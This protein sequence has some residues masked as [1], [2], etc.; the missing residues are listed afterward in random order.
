ME[1]VDSLLQ[2]NK[3]VGE[4]DVDPSSWEDL[5]FEPPGPAIQE[6]PQM[7]E[8]ATSSE[9]A[10]PGIQYSATEIF[11]LRSDRARG[12]LQL[13]KAELE[14]AESR[15]AG[16]LCEPLEAFL[17]EVPEESQ[18]NGYRYLLRAEELWNLTLDG[19]GMDVADAWKVDIH[20]AMIRKATYKGAPA[21]NHSD[22][23]KIPFDGLSR[24]FK[25]D[26]FSGQ[27]VCT[28]QLRALLSPCITEPLTIA[29]LPNEEHCGKLVNSWRRRGNLMMQAL[30]WL[31]QLGSF[32]DCPITR[33]FGTER[34]TW[35]RLQRRL[36]HLLCQAAERA[37]CSIAT[38]DMPPVQADFK[39]HPA[40]KDGRKL[41]GDCK[42][43]AELAIDRFISR[44]GG[45]QQA[46]YA[47]VHRTTSDFMCRYTRKT[48][49]TIKEAF[50]NMRIKSLG[51][52]CDSS[53]KAKMDA[54]RLLS[55][56]LPST[57]P[58]EDK[59]Q[60]AEMLANSRSTN[61]VADPKKGELRK[62]LPKALNAIKQD[63]LSSRQELKALINILSH[64]GVS[65]DLCWPRQPLIPADPEKEER[66]LHKLTLAF[67][68]DRQTGISKWDTPM[69]TDHVRL[70]ICPDQGGPMFCCYQYL[71]HLGASVALTRDELLLVCTVN[72]RVQAWPNHDNVH[73]QSHVLF[74][75]CQES[76]RMTTLCG[77]LFRAKKSPWNTSGFAATLAEARP[78]DILMEMFQ[79][80]I[81]KENGMEETTD[82]KLNFTRVMEILGQ[83]AK[84]CSFSHTAKRFQMSAT[85]LLIFWSAMEVGKNPF[86]ILEDEG[87]ATQNQK[88]Y[89]KTV[90]LCVKA[91]TNELS[92]GIFRVARVVLEPFRELCLELVP[93]LQFRRCITYESILS[94]ALGL[95]L[96]TVHELLQYSLYLRSS[97]H[98]AAGLISTKEPDDGNTK[99]SILKRMKAEWQVVLTMESKAASAATLAANCHHTRYQH[100]RE[101]M[102]CMEKN[103]YRM[104]TESK[105]MVSAWSPDFCQ[106]ASLESMFGDMSDAVKRAGRADCGGLASLHAVG[107][108]CLK[109]R[110]CGDSSESPKPVQLGKEA[111][112]LK[113]LPYKFQGLLPEQQQDETR[114]PCK[115]QEDFWDPLR[116]GLSTPALALD[117]G[118]DLIQQLR[119]GYDDVVLYGYS[120]HVCEKVLEDKCGS[121]ILIRRG[122]TEFSLLCYL[123]QTK[124]ILQTTCAS[125]HELLRK[126]DIQMPKSSTK[127]QQIRRL[128][129]LADVT[130][131]CDLIKIQGILSKLD[132]QDDKKKKKD[133]SKDDEQQD[134]EG[135]I[136]WEELND[137]PATVACKELLSRLDEEEEQEE[138]SEG[139]QE[140]PSA[141]GREDAD[142][143][144]RALLSCSTASLPEKLLASMPVPAECAIHQTV[145]CDSTLPHF[146]GRLLNNRCFE[147]KSLGLHSF[148]RFVRC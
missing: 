50:A 4:I 112:R 12:I 132:E 104:T 96:S 78:D 13:H 114:V 116:P 100:Y 137:D 38:S 33:H 51:V 108:R 98:C 101:V 11:Y 17:P 118:R 93:R 3:P 15:D 122:F 41:R 7:P 85:L 43:R 45:T 134:N 55:L 21:R 83:T 37:L 54:S 35:S 77:W 145:H 61:L 103:Q 109:H 36:L 57:A 59:L 14:T 72:V 81:L 135:D 49:T 129:M 76:F 125:L 136:Q 26:S 60:V 106:S 74:S 94:E 62:K 1:F 52:L 127:S 65:L 71:A 79:R 80:D 25:S 24:V 87:A 123:V 126:H 88:S 124:Q 42:P 9:T 140:R 68:F 144:S 66:F 53:P 19:L 70:V 92:F 75:V 44:G 143:V 22:R 84:W 34:T 46:D 30:M 23:L 27:A 47:F 48:E 146:Q 133:S 110:V 117:L 111:V 82:I 121:C 131:V 102:A 58:A 31:S 91:L 2:D 120:L 142:R 95:Y 69:S 99:Q 113:Q 141:A 67:L 6:A 90:D 107:V 128:L 105:D 147:G 97:P 29:L 73:G 89:D 148:I 28:E 18:M 10:S 39:F 139:E 20:A 63:R 56:L 8:D 130:E 5:L 138:T 16:Q 64:V 86:K 119:F 40:T 32:F 115:Q